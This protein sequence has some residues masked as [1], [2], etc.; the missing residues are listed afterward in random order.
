MPNEWNVVNPGGSHRVVVT[1]QLVGDR[2]LSILSEAGCRVEYCTSREIL[3]KDDILAAFGESCVGAIGQLTEVWDKSVLARFK[4]VGGKVYSNVAVGYNNVDITAATAL[5]I[6]VGN[7]PGVL[8]ETT[9]ELTVALTMAVA[10]RIVEADTFLREGK[11]KSWELTMFLG[12]LLRR[13]TLGVVGAG[14]IGSSYAKMMVEA[15]RMNLL[16]FDRSRNEQLE[17][18]LARFD[19]FLSASGEELV[20]VRRVESIEE[21]LS[22]SDVVSLHPTLNEST[23]HLIGAKE[24][25]RMKENAIL[26]NAS[27]GPVVDESALVDH[28]RRHANFRAGLDVYENEPVLAPGLT[29]LKNVVLLPHIGSATCWTREAM[30]TIAARNVAGVISGFPLWRSEDMSAFFGLDPPR[31]IPSIVNGGELG[32]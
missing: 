11:F 6:P 3:S 9:A 30:S 15:H 25:E 31:A 28:C 8:T 20:S 23:R 19:A 17:D 22:Q 7:T 1:K 12:A 2:W 5:R 4:S 10:R 24:L 26:I 32:L 27:R 14:R 21:V 18:E 16:Y 13:K 29:S